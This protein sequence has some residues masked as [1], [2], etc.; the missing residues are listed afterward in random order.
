MSDDL[1][2]KAADQFLRDWTEV[3]FGRPSIH[4]IREALIELVKF[5]GV[6]KDAFMAEI[7][8][9]A[10][11]EAA[12]NGDSKPFIIR[13]EHPDDDP[14]DSLCIVCPWCEATNEIVEVDKALRWNTIN[15]PVMVEGS[16][17]NPIY[18]ATASTDNNADYE[19]DGYLCRSCMNDKIHEP[20]NF[21]ITEWY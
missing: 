9:Q 21:E 1:I 11:E 15:E 7:E 18:Q 3:D 2:E 10:A 12:A 8:R 13:P 5:Q 14:L 4:N 17:D 6:T 19:G 20:S 16:E